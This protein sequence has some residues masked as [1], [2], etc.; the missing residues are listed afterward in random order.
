[1]KEQTTFR[2]DNDT[3]NKLKASAKSN[4]RSPSRA[5]QAAPLLCFEQSKGRYIDGLCKNVN[6]GRKKVYASVRADIAERIKELAANHCR[7]A[8]KEMGHAVFIYTILCDMGYVDD[9]GL[10][11]EFFALSQGKLKK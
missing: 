5:A 7:T 3:Y 11:D 8:S 1:M 10:T 2:P 4:M 6:T 9:F